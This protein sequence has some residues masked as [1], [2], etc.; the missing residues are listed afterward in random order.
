MEVS[1]T[2]MLEQNTQDK[3]KDQDSDWHYSPESNTFS[4]N[5]PATGLEVSIKLLT[6]SDNKMLE[7]SKTQKEKQSAI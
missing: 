6:P 2:S 1:L 7:E 4:F 3:E 5:L